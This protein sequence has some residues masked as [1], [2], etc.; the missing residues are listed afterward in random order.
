MRVLPKGAGPCGAKACQ[1]PGLPPGHSVETRS[2]ETPGLPTGSR[3]ASALPRWESPQATPSC[4]PGP[5]LSR[6]MPPT[7]LR[8]RT[9]GPK[10]STPAHVTCPPLPTPHPCRP[11]PSSPGQC[12]PLLPDRGACASP[13]PPP[14]TSSRPSWTVDSRLP[15]TVAPALLG[16]RGSPA[17]HLWG[18]CRST[19]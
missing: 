14:P 17:G 9:R 1:P 16:P 6:Q 15:R 12:P 4:S 19:Q 7:Q 10:T 18:L 3:K 13:P 2:V 5:G 8:Q 11:S